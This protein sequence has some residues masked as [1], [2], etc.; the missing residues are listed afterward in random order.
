MR[1]FPRQRVS[2][3]TGIAATSSSLSGMIMSLQAPQRVQTCSKTD[4]DRVD[5][6]EL[7]LI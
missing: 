6:D 2:T 4:H 3:R 1:G 7:M 5:D